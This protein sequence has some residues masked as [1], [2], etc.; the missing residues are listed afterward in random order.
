[1]LQDIRFLKPTNF[2]QSLVAGDTTTIALSA[3]GLD[4]LFPALQSNQELD[5]EIFTDSS[6]A[7]GLSLAEDT[8]FSFMINPRQYFSPPSLLPLNMY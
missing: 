4:T 7:N 6:N 8:V 2:L 3:I 1:M 5:V